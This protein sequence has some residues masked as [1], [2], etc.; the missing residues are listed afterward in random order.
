MECNFLSKGQRRALVRPYQLTRRGRSDSLPH[1]EAS[2]PCVPPRPTSKTAR[3]CSA[4]SFQDLKLLHTVVWDQDLRRVQAPN[5]RSS[6]R[7][8]SSR[9]LGVVSQ[10]LPLMHMPA[11]KGRDTKACERRPR[12][13]ELN[14]WPFERPKLRL[15]GPGMPGG[16]PVTLE[17]L[18]GPSVVG[19]GCDV[20]AR[21]GQSFCNLFSN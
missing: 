4:L 7:V 21:I 9:S 3:Y 1:S 17:K 5:W 16:A 10:R 13:R 18:S 20:R 14:Y 6:S 8:G 19:E 12:G 11:L 15:C 2:M